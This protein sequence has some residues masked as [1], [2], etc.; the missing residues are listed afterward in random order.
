MDKDLGSEDIA[1]VNKHI[2]RAKAQA[3]WE[4]IGLG[5]GLSSA[6][7]NGIRE[8]SSRDDQRLYSTLNAWVNGK[9]KVQTTWRVLIRTL[10]SEDI[11]ESALANT[12][13]AEK[14]RLHLCSIHHSHACTFVLI[15]H[16]VVILY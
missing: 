4:Q 8:G 5:L 1:S 2:R 10:Q 9:D 6:T 13:M 3:K 16:T 11:N 15:L 14:G 12:I 7:I